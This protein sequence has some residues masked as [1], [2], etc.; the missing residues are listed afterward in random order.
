MQFINKQ[1][2]EIH[3]ANTKDEIKSYEA[4][5]AWELVETKKVKE[6]AKEVKEEAPKEK[7]EKKSIL[8]KLFKD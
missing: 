5:Q 8:D 6:P 4:N 1:S 2:G 7:K 3:S